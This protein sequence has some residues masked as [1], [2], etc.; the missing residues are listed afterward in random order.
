VRVPVQI[1]CYNLFMSSDRFTLR[2]AVY[3]MPIKGDQI[4]LLRRFNTGWMD[5]HFSLVAGHLDGNE[6]VTKAMAREA[7][8]EEAVIDIDGCDLIPVTVLHRNSPDAEYVDFFFVITKWQ[9]EISIGEPDKC[10][11]LAWYPIDSLPE[12][13]LPYI[14]EAIQNYKEKIAFSGS[15]WVK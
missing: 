4:L 6:S 14:K 7:K 10:D 1:A 15:G 8:E 13:T 9:G 11:L 12:K 3:L 5:G 2:G